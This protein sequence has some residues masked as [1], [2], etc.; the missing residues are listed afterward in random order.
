MFN[1]YKHNAI[2]QAQLNE[3]CD[4]KQAERETKKKE[5]MI[6]N[7]KNRIKNFIYKVS[8]QQ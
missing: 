6:R 5:E 1:M 8:K 7:H 3:K 2:L 4:I